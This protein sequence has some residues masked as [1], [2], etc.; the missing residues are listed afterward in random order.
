MGTQG[1]G[2]YRFRGLETYSALI[3]PKV[4]ALQ[5]SR[6]S[7]QKADSLITSGINWQRK[8]SLEAGAPGEEVVVAVNRHD[9]FKFGDHRR[10]PLSPRLG[11]NRNLCSMMQVEQRI[12]E[13]TGRGPVAFLGEFAQQKLR[14][15]STQ[16]QRVSCFLGSG[17]AKTADAAP[18]Q[19]LMIRG[20]PGTL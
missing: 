10:H 6:A 13:A 1:R 7:R 17:I 12:C 15:R 5:D 3:C 16:G 11:A 20:F 18:R 2:V 9:G 19:V 4:Q 8:R 14:H